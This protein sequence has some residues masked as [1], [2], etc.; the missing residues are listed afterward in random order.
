MCHDPRQ[1]ILVPTLNEHESVERVLRTIAR[2]L[3]HA[4]VLVIDDDSRDGTP[5]VVESLKAELPRV[6]LVVRRGRPAG[7]GHS[8]RDGYRYA[9]DNGYE[10]VCIVDCDLQQ[11]PADI[12]RMRQAHPDADLVIGS[13][14]MGPGGFV[15]GYNRAS[16]W[17]S[18]LGNAALR[19]LFQFP[20]RDA[21][22]DFC[23]I[24]TRVLRLIRP[25]SLVSQGYAQFLELK[26]RAWKAGFRVAEEAVPTYERADGASHRTW[27]Q[28]RLFAGEVLAV[29]ADVFLFPR[30][31]KSSEE[32]D[33]PDPAIR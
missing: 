22:T 11:D 2:C 32:S 9:L 19:L 20:Y 7:L 8:I 24:T 17:T 16:K 21:T 4:N 10:E 6:G 5:E 26:V 30:A 28:V 1:L 13:R 25:E 3:P 15:R 23:L 18:L 12:R 33:V 31:G 14:L 29:W 27:R